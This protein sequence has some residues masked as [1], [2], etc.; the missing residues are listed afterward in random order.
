VL[1]HQKNSRTQLLSQQSAQ[2]VRSFVAEMASTAKARQTSEGAWAHCN[3]A[4]GNKSDQ[5]LIMT[6][7]HTLEWLMLLPDDLQPN[8]DS[9]VNSCKFMCKALTRQKA[10]SA[11]DRYCPYSHC[12]RALLMLSG[13]RFDIE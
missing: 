8:V 4:K 7:G 12:L 9:I 11:N 3:D 6:T 13:R 10:D 1:L 5:T 2:R